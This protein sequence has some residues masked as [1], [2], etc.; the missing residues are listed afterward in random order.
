MTSEECAIIVADCWG[1]LAAG[2]RDRQSPMHVPVVA[3]IA[4]D[5]APDQRVM[6][7][8][9]ADP[10]TATLRFNADAR[11][12]KLAQVAAHPA[13]HVLAYDPI[14]KVQLR[15]SGLGSV[16]ACGTN[17]DDAWDAATLFAR[18]CYLATK[19]PGTTSATATSGL[20]AAIEGIKPSADEIAR[21]RPNFA[22]LSV[23]VERIDWLYLANS[24]HRRAQLTRAGS[25]WHGEWVVP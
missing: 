17:A 4:A 8:R 9:G 18:R 2:A 6:V 12:P 5:G 11:S 10:E 7:L 16:D 14:A 19:A 13:V 1:L 23:A 22:T 25:G 20:P 15:L 24:G 21:G 3:S